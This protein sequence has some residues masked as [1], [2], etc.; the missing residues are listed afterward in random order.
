MTGL[1]RQLFIDGICEQHGVGELKIA[2]LIKN[3]KHEPRY[4]ERWEGI[5]PRG[6]IFVRN[7]A[8]EKEI[9]REVIRLIHRHV[10]E[11]MEW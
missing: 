10:S 1:E 7:K 8:S 2:V 6:V 9:E 4:Y 5:P 11:T 3:G